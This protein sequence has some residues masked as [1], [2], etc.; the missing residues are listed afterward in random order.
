MARMEIIHP[1]RPHLGRATIRSP[2]ILATHRGTGRSSNQIC[3]RGTSPRAN[4]LPVNWNCPIRDNDMM[5]RRNLDSTIQDPGEPSMRYLTSRD[6]L[7]PRTSER[8]LEKLRLPIPRRGWAAKILAGQQERT[9]WVT[10]KTC[11]QPKFRS[12]IW[13]LQVLADLG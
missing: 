1:G 12:T 11:Y 2:G 10:K 13:R 4:D 6:L 3:F 7:E 8:K 5:P 9:W